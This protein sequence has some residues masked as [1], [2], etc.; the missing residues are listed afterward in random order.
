MDLNI[1]WEK[2]DP[3]PSSTTSEMSIKTIKLL[4]ENHHTNH[5]YLKQQ[6]RGCERSSRGRFDSPGWVW[7][8][9][10]VGA[11][12]GTQRESWHGREVGKG[13]QEPELT[14]RNVCGGNRSCK[15]HLFPTFEVLT[16]L[17]G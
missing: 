9:Q 17:Q 13:L 5:L 10:T 11:A 6:V 7:S 8:V 12:R 16:L 1:P 2:E 3:N 14:P 15:Q 4:H